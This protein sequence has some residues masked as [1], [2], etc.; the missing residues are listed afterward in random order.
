V[1]RPGPITPWLAVA[2]DLATRARRYARRR[3][4]P[5]RPLWTAP[6]PLLLYERLLRH[7]TD[8]GRVAFLTAA[9][10]EARPPA[11]RVAVYLRH[12]LDVSPGMLETMARLEADQ[13]IR[14]SLQLRVDGLDF[15]PDPVA[16]LLR[17]LRAAG[18]EVGLHTRAYGEARPDAAL[19]GELTRFESLI[20]APPDS[21]STHGF[22]PTSTAV[23]YRRLRFRWRLAR[24]GLR[25]A[26]TP[27]GRHPAAVAGD[28]ARLPGTGQRF[29]GRDVLALPDTGPGAWALWLTH[30]CYW[31]P[32]VDEATGG[33]VEA[34]CRDGERPAGTSRS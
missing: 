6:Y 13:G 21:V 18:F 31:T 34:A 7:L 17:D 19:D 3:A 10:I 12:D 23:L 26:E 15:A 16:G 2:T 8:S 4:A 25:S 22:G 5:V 29:L 1:R 9:A 20:G 33:R 24:R 11:D 27:G 32:A 28:S 30:P 14:S